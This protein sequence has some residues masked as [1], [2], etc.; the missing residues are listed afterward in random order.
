[1]RNILS[2]KQP[3]QGKIIKEWISFHNANETEY[4]PI[5]SQMKRF[6]NISDDNLYCIDMR[7]RMTGY[8]RP[9]RS[10]RVKKRKIRPAVVRAGKLKYL[11]QIIVNKMI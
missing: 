9:N 3:L 10:W 1:M 11:E 5:A 8:L 7:P 2:Y 4:T 6:G